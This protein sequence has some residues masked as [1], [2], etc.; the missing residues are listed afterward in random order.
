MTDAPTKAEPE[1]IADGFDDVRGAAEYLSIS[2]SKVYELMDA[3][4]LTY[5]KFGKSRRIPRRAIRAYA[6]ENLVARDRRRPQAG[7]PT[8]VS[9]SFNH[10]RSLLASPTKPDLSPQRR[11]SSAGNLHLD[12][13]RLLLDTSSPRPPGRP[14]TPPK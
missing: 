4:M 9:M 7:R 14:P 8:G 6:A 10:T 2:R 13:T 12:R 3:G 5:A 11:A 1:C